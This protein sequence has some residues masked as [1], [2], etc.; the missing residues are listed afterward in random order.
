MSASVKV[1]SGISSGTEYW[2]DRP[3]MRVGSDP[4][5]EICILSADLSPH[6]ITIEHRKGVYLV[7][8]RS[9]DSA[10]IDGQLVCAGQPAIWA[11][12]HVLDLNGEHELLLRVAGDPAPSAKPAASNP[13][14][15]D[16][17]LADETHVSGRDPVSAEARP[18]QAV[19]RSRMASWLVT[20]ICAAALMAL[21]L[22]DPPRPAAGSTAFSFASV[23]QNAMKSPRTS[24]ALVR[25]LQHAQAALIRGDRDAARQYFSDLRDDLLQQNDRFLAEH[26]EPELAILA[27]VEQQLGSVR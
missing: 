9:G 19:S 23:V 2:I 21:L 11:P 6:A 17:E 13:W 16:P 10:R 24:P 20:G 12:N 3:V 27:F 5:A 1:L 25:R 14:E 7:Y 22:V 8:L 4:A 26:R 15:G 18:I